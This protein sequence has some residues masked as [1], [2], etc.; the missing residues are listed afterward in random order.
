MKKSIYIV[1]ALAAFTF[2]SCKKDYECGCRDSAG[3][4]WASY[5]IHTTKKK[6]KEA[7]SANDAQWASVG[8]TCTI[9]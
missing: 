9:E 4:E 2:T 5:K 3:Y 7:C 6:A 1:A 8:G